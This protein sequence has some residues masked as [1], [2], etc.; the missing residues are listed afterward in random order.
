M[1]QYQVSVRTRPCAVFSPNASTSLM[2][3][4]RPAKFWPPA[5]D[6][7]FGRLLDRVDRIA[8]GIGE[9]DDLGFRGLRLQ[10]EGGEVVKC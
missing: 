10:Q 5:G 6:A 7:E 4:K 9:P 3:T 2:K 8:A 1:S